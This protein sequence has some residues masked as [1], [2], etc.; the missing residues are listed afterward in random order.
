MYTLAQVLA[1]DSFHQ[2]MREIL[3]YV[4]FSWVYFYTY[5]AIASLV[6]MNLVTAIIV[7]NAMET[8]RSDKEQMY[9][10]KE[11]ARAKEL[12]D[13]ERMFVEMDVDGSGTLCWDEFDASFDDDTLRKKWILLDFRH[14][15]C[16]AL[17]DLLDN[18]DG[19][20]SYDEFFEGLFKMRGV[21]QAKDM[22]LLQKMVQKLH[23]RLPRDWSS[24]GYMAR[25][26]SAR[27]QSDIGSPRVRSS[28]S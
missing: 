2:F 13:L 24:E 11:A 5:I 19:E 27:S 8:S 16:R 17:F 22:F 14:E 20:V 7:D 15:D 10:D 6:L 18:G 1:G 21:A 26:R 9:S 3:I 23:R 28:M 25:V 12:K 4:P